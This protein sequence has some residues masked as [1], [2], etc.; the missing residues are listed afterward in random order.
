M[1]DRARREGGPHRPRRSAVAGVVV[2]PR[3]C[4]LPNRLVARTH[5]AGSHDR[6]DPVVALG[7]EARQSTA[8]AGRPGV[9]VRGAHPSDGTGAGTGTRPVGAAPLA[10]HA[11]RSRGLGRARPLSPG[12]PAD[13]RAQRTHRVRLGGS[14]RAGPESV[15]GGCHCP[16]RRLSGKSRRVAEINTAA[17][18]RRD[19]RASRR[20]A[21]P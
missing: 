1:P 5:A 13:A 19:W 3:S 7:I 2:V 18:R 8:P 6:A 21:K 17:A 15:C 20:H 4:E 10:Q 14:S 9:R 11:G 16:N 12:K